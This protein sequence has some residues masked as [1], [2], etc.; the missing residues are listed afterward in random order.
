VGTAADAHRH[1]V[2]RIAQRVLDEVGD[3]AFQQSRVGHDVGQVGRDVDSDRLRGWVELI[4][5]PGH[6]VVKAD[7]CRQDRQSSGLQPRQVEQIGDQFGE[8]VEGRVRV[9]EQ[10]VAVGIGPDDIARA[11][12]GNCRFGRC[13]RG[14]QI[15][16]DGVEERGAGPF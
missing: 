6:D 3:H 16:A 13:Y 9:A 11:K 14:A 10:F 15:M 2:R 7:R 1:A 12:A 5:G 4:E 8:L